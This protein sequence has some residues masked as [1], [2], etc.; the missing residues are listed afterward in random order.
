[1]SSGRT[2]KGIKQVTSDRTKAPSPTLGS[3]V[4]SQPPPYNQLR[5]AG[6][7][8]LAHGQ[9]MMLEIEHLP[10]GLFV[11]FPA[12]LDSFSDA[13]N[14]EWSS[15]QVYGRMDPIA[16]FQ[17]TR[18][19]VS[20]SWMIP[21]E[22]AEAA[23]DNLN[24]VN[25][26][27][28]FLYPL[29][30]AGTGANINMAPLLRVKFGNLIQDSATGGGLL[31]YVNGF[32]MDPEMDAG[33]FVW[34]MG[35]DDEGDGVEYYPKAIRLNFEMTVLHEHPLGWVKRG[36]DY[37]LRGGEQQGFPYGVPGTGEGLTPPPPKSAAPIPKKPDGSTATPA[38]EKPMA[39]RQG[40]AAAAQA[41]AAVLQPA[42]AS[43]TND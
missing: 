12:F 38:P 33:M 27:L 37:Y 42:Q 23:V 20:V 25:T 30:E 11:E 34:S 26:L 9:E 22:S 35:Y 5:L 6:V 36:S 17:S 41:N 2:K 13:Y 43:K 15:E 19:A 39:Q 16:T 40:P 29:Y 14:S 1:M 28:Q 21:A 18:R 24:N 10:T 3:L 8:N 7:E 32:T 31:G 4:T